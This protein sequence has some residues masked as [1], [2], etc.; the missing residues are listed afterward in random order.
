M[1]EKMS[2]NKTG[3]MINYKKITSLSAFNGVMFSIS[4]LNLTSLTTNIFIAILFPIAKTSGINNFI[5]AINKNNQVSIYQKR[6]RQ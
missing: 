3:C 1:K 2:S 5:P 6:Q 4:Q